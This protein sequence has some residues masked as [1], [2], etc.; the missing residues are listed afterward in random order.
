MKIPS[1]YL[2][3]MPYLIVRNAK[4]FF[5]FTQAVFGATEQLLAPTDDGKI[6]HGEIKIGDAVIMFADAGDNWKEKTA[7][8]YIYVS[9]VDA[10][11]NTAIRKGAKSL[12]PPMKKDYGYTAEFE[13]PFGN[14]WFLTQAEK[15]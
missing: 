1:H 15:E 10:V 6:M 8:M 4:T 14:F 11:Y 5:E 9:D 13:D 12:G 7:G 3:V 2:P